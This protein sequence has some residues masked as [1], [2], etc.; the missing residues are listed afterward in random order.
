[1]SP[2]QAQD[3]AEAEAF[4]ARHP[5]TEV[6]DLLLCDANGILRGKRV[7]AD[8]LSKAYSPGILLAKSLFAQDVT[9][10]TAESA[11]IGFETGDM[12]CVCT[13]VPGTL[14]R[15]PW[16]E[17]PS[18]QALLRMRDAHGKP[19]A[20]DPQSVLDTVLD[21]FREIGL[22]PV[23]A[24]ELEFYLI[25]RMRSAAGEPQLPIS[26][27]TGAR[28]RHLNVYGITDLDDYGDLL[29][30]MVD[31]AAVQGIPADTAVSEAS[32][33]QFEINLHHQ[34]D[35][36]LACRH[37]LMLKR[38]IKGVARKHGLEATFMPKPLPDIAGSGTHVHVS[39]VDDAGN[40]VFALGEQPVNDTLKNAIAGLAETM[41]ESML[42][43]APNANSYRRFVA[44]WF[45]PLTPTWGLNNRTVALR[46]P[47]GDTAARRIEHRL[48][49]ADVNPFLLTAAVLAGMH[50][51]ITNGLQPGPLTSGN[52]YEKHPP[53]LPITWESTLKAFERAEIIPDYLGGE[54]CRI[55]TAIKREE[56]DLF[57]L[58]ITPLEYDWYLRSS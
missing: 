36:L 24:I 17:K 2:S 41:A 58:Q 53:S 16:R 45:V 22:T 31:A 15:V 51:G 55:F 12:D 43:F 40:N 52:A 13:P 14:C 48:A 7:R 21:R 29:G 33:A 57:N 28:E 47:G 46:V 38:V 10:R 20:G 50:H 30:E 26:P 19:Y 56:Y 32:P 34:A 5:D 35:A 44:E 42:I 9:G 27:V 54:F 8:S 18:A 39:L 37:A 1:M 6:V 25:D 49:G 4:L 3:P 23:V 11:G